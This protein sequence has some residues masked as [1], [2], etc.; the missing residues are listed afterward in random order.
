[1]TVT[2]TRQPQGI[3]AGGQFAPLTRSEPSVSLDTPLTREQALDLSTLVPGE[4]RTI[5]RDVHGID[6]IE[7][8]T[9]TDKGPLRKPSV[10]LFIEPSAAARVAPENHLFE[11]RYTLPAEANLKPLYEFDDWS[12]RR[13][14]RAAQAGIEDLAGLGP[15][16]WPTPGSHLPETTVELDEEGDLAFTTYETYPQ[17][18]AIDHEDFESWA[19]EYSGYTDPKTRQELALRI[20][21]SYNS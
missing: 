17:G 13:A 3:P 6:G 1:M 9:L 10:P 18:G 20:Q 16:P 4:S 21:D 14:R 7:T 2:I 11:L 5:G 15:K 19:S 8:I 12:Y